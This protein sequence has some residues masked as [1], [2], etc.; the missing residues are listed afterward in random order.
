MKAVV[1]LVTLLCGCESSFAGRADF[2]DCPVTICHTKRCCEC[3]CDVTAGSSVDKM[4][5]YA[6]SQQDCLSTCEIHCEN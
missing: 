4:L 2:Y 3:D 5:C 6:S 1:A